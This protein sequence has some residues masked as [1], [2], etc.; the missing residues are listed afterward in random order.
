MGRLTQLTARISQI[1]RGYWRQFCLSLLIRS[2]VSRRFISRR[3]TSS[4]RLGS[5]AR[6]A[7]EITSDCFMP[8]NSAATCNSWWVSTV[9]LMFV[10]VT[11]SD[12]SFFFLGISTPNI[13]L[14]VLAGNTFALLLL[15]S[16]RKFTLFHLLIYA[17]RCKI[18]I[19]ART[20][21]TMM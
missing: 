3:S 8:V 14:F 21:R 19:T 18:V 12:F 10:V 9:T 7:A 17:N 15:N 4:V 16:N 20:A 2:A 6:N 1:F 13:N 11:L 5:N